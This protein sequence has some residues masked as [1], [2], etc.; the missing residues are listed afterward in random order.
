[1]STLKWGPEEL[2]NTTTTNDQQ[3]SSVAVLAGG[4]FV[5]VWEDDSGAFS[6]IRAQRYDAAGNPVSG[7]IGIDVGAG[8]D[9]VLA[10]SELP[11][12]GRISRH[13][14]VSFPLGYGGTFHGR[15]RR[16]KWVGVPFR[17]AVAYSKGGIVV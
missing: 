5:V 3:F 4:G 16:G 10:G 13:A 17:D 9:E 11:D 2:V 7:E 14:R 15:G 1:M 8:N 12:R 6:S